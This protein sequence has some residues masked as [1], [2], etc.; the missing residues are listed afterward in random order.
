MSKTLE[1]D[2]NDKEERIRLSTKR[3]IMGGISL[4]SDQQG[5]RR[6]T[7]YRT[8]TCTESKIRGSDTI[9][10]TARFTE[11]ERESRTRLSSSG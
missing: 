8:P 1:R 7:L 6:T 5:C 3:E 11:E 2:L 10:N 4:W 9:S